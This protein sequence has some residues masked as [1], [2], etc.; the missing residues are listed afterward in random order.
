MKDMASMH[1]KEADWTEEMLLSFN[2]SAW[3]HG[4]FSWLS[5][6]PGGFSGQGGNPFVEAASSATPKATKADAYGS[7]PGMAL[8]KFRIMGSR[9]DTSRGMSLQCGH[10]DTRCSKLLQKC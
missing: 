4:A 9:H 7:M 3:Q 6:A 2:P 8:G 10:L 5:L 1:E